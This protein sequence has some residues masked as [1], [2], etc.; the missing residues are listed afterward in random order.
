MIYTESMHSET[1]PMTPWPALADKARSL[2]LK[3][4]DTLFYYDSAGSA[5]TSGK[6]APASTVPKPMFAA[7]AIILVH[8]LGDE[9]DSWRHLIPH[10]N[11]AGCRTLALDLPGFGRSAAHGRINL[12]RHAEAVCRLMEETG[13]ASAAKPAILVGNSMGGAV[14]Q[15]AA[16][17][18]P[19]LVKALALIDGGLPLAV[20]ADRGTV[21]GALPI[22]GPRW[23]RAL[24]KDHAG[25]YRS[26]FD[27]Y[28]DFEKLPQPDREFLRERVI[29]RVESSA[30]ERAYFGSRRSTIW[31]SMTK[32]GVFSRR[33]TAFPGRILIIW[34][35]RDLLFPPAVA[36]PLRSLRPDAAFQVIPGAGHLPH[37]EKPE[38]TAEALLRF[39][40]AFSV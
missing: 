4:T 37:Q 28:G 31:A 27:F 24:R 19:D 16:A 18:K 29:A 17:K 23:Y 40:A 9:A 8:G 22:L 33:L 7:P 32:T 2:P 34:G 15:E 36:D 13:V 26:L 39:I 12:K 11:R 30:Q 6:P 3:G 20:K 35:E 21:T 14:V 38:E 1:Y 25:A 5:D 10:L